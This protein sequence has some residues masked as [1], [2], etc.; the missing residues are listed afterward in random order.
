MNKKTL[1]TNTSAKELAATLGLSPLEAM[2]WQIRH[3]ITNKIIECS[4][5][6][7]VTEIAKN[8]GTSRARITKILKSDTFGISIDVL[9]RVL[10]AVGEEIKISFKRAS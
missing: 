8:A 1:K 10:G 6:Y 2:E 9:I 4:Q 7:T 3:T 5:N